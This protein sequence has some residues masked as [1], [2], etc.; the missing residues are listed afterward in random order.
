MEKKFTKG[1]SYNS[2]SIV[3]NIQSLEA[4]FKSKYNI[5]ILGWKERVKYEEIMKK[6][7][8]NYSSFSFTKKK[9]IIQNSELKAAL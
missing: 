1:I 3:K 4:F 9:Q 2:E 5:P 7:Y 6:R 8:P